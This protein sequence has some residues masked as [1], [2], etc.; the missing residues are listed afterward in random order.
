MIVVLAGPSSV[1]KTTYAKKKYKNYHLIDSDEVWFELAKQYQ[2][3][4]ELVNKNLFPTIVKRALEYHQTVIIHT[5][6]QPLVKLLKNNYQIVL[7]GTNFKKLAR[8]LRNREMRRDVS[9][10][11]GNQESGFTY[12]FTLADKTETPNLF[13]RKKDLDLMPVKTKKDKKAVEDLKKKLFL[14]RETIRVKPKIKYDKF[15]I[16]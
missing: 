7:L 15:I 9:A 1:G 12:Y 3:N 5:D 14:D 4:R 6:P 2:W 16:I 11:L 13:L 8:N 10:V